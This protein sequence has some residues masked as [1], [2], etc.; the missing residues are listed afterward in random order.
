MS[1]INSKT[2]SKKKKKKKT[3]ESNQIKKPDLETTEEK[4]KVFKKEEKVAN[5]ITAHLSSVQNS[6]RLF[7]KVLQEHE[8]IKQSSHNYDEEKYM[9]LHNKKSSFLSGDIVL[10]LLPRLECNGILLVHHNL[11]F[12]DS[13]DS[14]ASATQGS[15]PKLEKIHWSN[16][17]VKLWNQ[18]FLKHEK[19]KGVLKIEDLA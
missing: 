15:K 1:H 11:Y 12:L 18:I 19:E 14:P 13:S 7:I 16:A 2:K 8:N 9:Y 17:K 10:L 3:K 6:V 4:E 5:E